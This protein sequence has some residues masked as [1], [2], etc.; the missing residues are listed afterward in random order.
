MINIYNEID[1]DLIL[2]NAHGNKNDEKIKIFNYTVYQS[3]KVNERNNGCAIAIKS[4]IKHRIREK[5][6]SDLLSIELD[7]ELG[8]IEIATSYV[9]PRVGYLHY[10]DFYRLL[11]QNHP[12]YYLGDL[13]ARSRELGSRSDN[14]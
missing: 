5:F 13:N 12:V 3:N 4:N 2:I 8:I 9:P 1:P 14:Q 10:P 7:T 6:H 11:K